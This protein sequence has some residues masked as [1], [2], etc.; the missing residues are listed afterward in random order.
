M[1]ETK[2]SL[3]WTPRSYSKCVSLI[4]TWWI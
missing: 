2:L 3:D 1:E 4:R